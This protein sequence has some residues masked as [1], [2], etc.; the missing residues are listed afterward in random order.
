MLVRSIVAARLMH[1][2][3]G[4]DHHYQSKTMQF[5][6]E[7]SYEPHSPRYQ[8]HTLGERP[9]PNGIHGRSGWGSRALCDLET[10]PVSRLSVVDCDG[11]WRIATQEDAGHV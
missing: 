7:Y 8:N 10:Q 4:A 2:S 9:Y 1:N 11:T 3:F 5:M 6:T